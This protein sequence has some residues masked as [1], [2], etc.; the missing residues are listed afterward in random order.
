MKNNQVDKTTSSPKWDLQT[1]LTFQT[2]ILENHDRLPL[3]HKKKYLWSRQKDYCISILSWIYDIFNAEIHRTHIEHVINML[4]SEFQDKTMK[5]I[6]DMT[7]KKYLSVLSLMMFYHKEKTVVYKLIGSVINEFID[8]FICLDYL[9]ILQ[10]FLFS[11]DN[12]FEKK[13]NNL[14]GLVVPKIIMNI[15]LCH[16]F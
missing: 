5:A 4:S 6:K 13:F 8:N 10:L 1:F 2:L 12:K 14:S 11:Y 9:G 7:Q 15:M 16:S 3:R